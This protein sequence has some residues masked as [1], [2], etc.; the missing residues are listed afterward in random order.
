MASIGDL[1][2]ELG[3]KADTKTINQVNSSIKGLRTNLL[4]VSAAFTGAIVGLD[5]FVNG[6][7][8]GV[9]ALQ[10]I[11]NQTDLSIEKLQ[12]FQQAGQL[13]N[14]ALSADQIA[15]SIGNVQKNLAQLRIGQGNLAPFQL[16]GI[17]VQ[18]EDAFGVIEQLRESI[19]GID[20][21]LATNLMSQIGLSPEFINILKLSREEFDA[22]ADNVFLSGKQ[23]AD[24]DKVGTSIK[25]LTLRFKALKDQAVAKLAPELDKLVKQFFKWIKDNGDK[26]IKTITSLARGFARFSQAIGSAF[27]LVSR[28]VEKLFG[29]ENGIKAIAVAL[30]FL[31]LSF[32]PVLAN[33]T[34][35]ILILDDIAA[36]QRGGESII[37]ELVKA[38][39]SLPVLGKLLV[40]AVGVAGII[41]LT[42]AVGKLGVALKVLIT[43]LGKISILAGTIIGL[44]DVINNHKE[45]AKKIDSTET[46]QKIGDFLFN[47]LE[48]TKS[49]FGVSKA[50]SFTKNPTDFSAAAQARPLQS[51]SN[52]STNKTS[53][54][55]NNVININGLQDPVAVKN[56]IQ[57]SLIPITQQDLNR[58]LANQ[59]RGIR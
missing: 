12:Q 28:F 45:I 42:S 51:T 3:I 22:L 15:Q 16:L 4:L 36:F 50:E 20:P 10:N 43:P 1:F 56:E 32:S 8:K 25:A 7:L 46:G 33:F 21:A 17:D 57:R 5:R 38:F 48:S 6:T 35:L 26:I 11:N 29:M 54:N 59:G 52:I 14:L 47:T 18:D 41:E 13:S 58:T 49:L 2:I 44:A 39:D 31:A 23:R 24:I 30:G 34:A 37:G 19:K 53:A 40:G 55:I 9:V 27:S